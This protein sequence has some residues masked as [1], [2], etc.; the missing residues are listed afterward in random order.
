MSSRQFSI[1]LLAANPALSGILARTLEHEG[2]YKVASF[3][4]VAAL[5]IYLRL[6]P[7]DVVVLDTDIPGMPA[8]DIARG[9][10]SQTTLASDDFA[11]VALTHTPA[12]FHRPLF[13]AGIDEVLQKP[14]SPGKLLSVVAE[15]TE[16]QRTFAVGNGPDLVAAETAQPVTQRIGNVIPLFGEGRTRR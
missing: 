8:M 10:R 12:P 16:P 1:A 15:L 14:V 6:T 13:H 4:G 9:L 5:T 7:V 3:E 11:I 2:G